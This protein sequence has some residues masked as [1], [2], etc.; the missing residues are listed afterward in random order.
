MMQSERRSLEERMFLRNLYI[1][2]IVPAHMIGVSV[3]TRAGEIVGFVLSYAL[4]TTILFFVLTFFQKIPSHWTYFHVM[5]IT[6]T[7][8]LCGVL[9]EKWLR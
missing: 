2:R 1:T 9:L 7:I 3:S 4:F 5:G 8:V 6:S